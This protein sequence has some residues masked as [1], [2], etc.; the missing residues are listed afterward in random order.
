MLNHKIQSSRVLS[1]MKKSLQEL[2]ELS[3]KVKLLLNK[4][5][6]TKSTMIVNQR[7]T[8]RCDKIDLKKSKTMSYDVDNFDE[9]SDEELFKKVEIM[10]NL[11]PKEKSPA[12]ILQKS[13][14]SSNKRM[15][16]K[17]SKL[18]G[19]NC[20]EESDEDFFKNVEALLSKDVKKKPTK[21]ANSKC[22]V[23]SDK[24]THNT[25]TKSNSESI[26]K[27]I[28]GI[29]QNIFNINTTIK[30]RAFKSLRQYVSDN[31]Q[32]FQILVEM[33]ILGIVKEG[34]NNKSEIIRLEGLRIFKYLV[35]YL[36]NKPEVE[37]LFPRVLRLVRRFL[38]TQN[39]AQQVV[40]KEII[41]TI[42]DLELM[43]KAEI[44]LRS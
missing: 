12:K 36:Y 22:S 10:L 38:K 15:V 30:F 14:T 37:V 44:M 28:R 39:N 32:H 4:E 16:F 35:R 29:F 11:S 18:S 41:D 20:V 8:S 23:K 5:S 31:E 25:N 9:E 13:T 1:K 40:A 2:E 21:N 7:C 43:E 26:S 34:L 42:D 27:N 33:G 17:S 19:D 3:K 24:A 6:D